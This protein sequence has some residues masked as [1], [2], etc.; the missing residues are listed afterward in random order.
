MASKRDLLSK[1]DTDLLL[2]LIHSSLSCEQEDDLKGLIATVK[3]LIPYEFALCGFGMVDRAA[4]DSFEVIN[5]S[6]P[7]QWMELYVARGFDRKDPI[8]RE[9]ARAFGLQ[10]WADT[11]RKYEDSRLF[12]TSAADFGLNAGYSYGLRSSSGDRTSLFSFAGRSMERDPRTEFILEYVVPHMH[13]AFSR[14]VDRDRDRNRQGP[15]LSV[16]EKEILKWARDG[17]STWEI[18]VILSISKDTVK[19]HIKN[20]MQ[21]LQAVTRTQAVAVAIEHRL[22]GIE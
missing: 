5:A 14:I 2:E 7:A 12:V 3:R 4:G 9:N 11:F 17:K 21:K 10:Y 22:I 18:S 8:V 13:Q 1:G 15:Q 16:R 6:Y 19:F 20:I